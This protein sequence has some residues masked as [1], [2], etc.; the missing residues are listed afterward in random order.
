MMEETLFSFSGTGVFD[1]P[2]FSRWVEALVQVGKTSGLRQKEVLIN[3]TALNLKRM[4]RIYKT[5]QLNKALEL[6]VVNLK[7]PQH[8]YVIT[9]A[10]C[11]DSAQI[12]PVL[13]RI[14]ESAAGKIQL[15]IFLRDENPEW[16]DCYLTNGNRSIPKL[17]AFD[18]NMKEIFTW[19]RA[20]KLHNN[21][22]WTGNKL[23]MADR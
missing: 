9:E 23:Q 13:A 6:A 15:H 20:P 1:Y 12:L 10:W 17:I 8:W 11:G 7:I 16:M 5:T 14:A 18:K 3:F 2:G 22:Y 4:Q 21:Y 19:G